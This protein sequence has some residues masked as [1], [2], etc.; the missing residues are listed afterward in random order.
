[1]VRRIPGLSV[2]PGI[3]HLEHVLVHHHVV[4]LAGLAWERGPVSRLPRV[5]TECVLK[6][7]GAAAILTLEIPGK[8]NKVW[9][10]SHAVFLT[11]QACSVHSRRHS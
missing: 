1:M 7:D 4:D 9:V 3:L 2:Y 11:G 5:G 6:K 10:S 8:L